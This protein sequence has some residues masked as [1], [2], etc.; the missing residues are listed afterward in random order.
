MRS[1]LSV[2]VLV[3]WSGCVIAQTYTATA[4]PFS[5]GLS[6]GS[7][8]MGGTPIND[9]G[10]IIG[11]GT[12]PGGTVAGFVYNKGKLT[13]LGTSLVPTSINNVGQIAG[14]N[15]SA[16]SHMAVIFS[17]GKLSSLGTLGSYLE[18]H[19]ST[20]INYSFASGINSSGQVIGRSSSPSEGESP[21]L[22]RTGT[23]TPLSIGSSAVANGINN[24]GRVTG[25]FFAVSGTFHAF[26]YSDGSLSDLGTLGGTQSFA[27]SINTAGQVTGTADTAAGGP[28]DAFLYANGT[29]KDLGSL[30]GTGST[31]YAIN[32][33]GQV[34]GLS[35]SSAGEASTQTTA[36]LWTGTNVINLNTALAQPLPANVSLIQ[37]IGINDNGW[38]VANARDG[39]RITAY[40]LTP[41][42]SLTLACP[43]AAS[44]TGVRYSSA[45]IAAGG[46]PPYRLSTTGNLP[47]GLTLDTSTGI[48]SGTPGVA[49][50]F[51]LSAQVIDTSG[52]ASGTVTSNCSITVSPA[53]LQ[54]SVFPSNISFGQVGRFS[55]LHNTVTVMNTGTRRV[56]MSKVS[57]A[58]G[59]GTHRGDFTAISLCGASLA[60]G[61]SCPIYVIVFAHNLGSLSA[62]L[63]IPTNANGSPQTVPLNVTVTPRRH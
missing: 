16:G 30:N 18:P 37:A 3:A 45:L 15:E 5:V 51:R 49:G 56:S 7:D 25:A 41:V 22:Y 59:A 19:N 31:G 38:I 63:N 61:R 32:N 35:R 55:V 12:N 28:R 58:A 52:I 57:V 23:M 14:T 53:S 34:V 54:L 43:A 26:V 9:A 60:P 6:T 21:F 40:L 39:N 33:A 29:M 50:S 13:Y 10:Q 20:P 11:F 62:V 8:F 46:I 2:V 1:A 36:T 4:L 48:L 27:S 47:A 17:S 44:E 24:A 42:P